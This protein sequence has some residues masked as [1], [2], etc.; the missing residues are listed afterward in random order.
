[1]KKRNVTSLSIS[2]RGD[3]SDLDNQRAEEPIFDTERNDASQD[4]MRILH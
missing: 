4:V 1:M 3:L 2:S